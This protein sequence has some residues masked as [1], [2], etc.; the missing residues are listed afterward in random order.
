MGIPKI[1]CTCIDKCCAASSLL[2]SIALEEAAI[3]NILNAEGKKINKVLCLEECEVKTILDTNKS[4]QDTIEKIT[5]LENV[6]KDKLELIIPIIE[7]CC[8]KHHKMDVK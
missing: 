6:L 4:V 8:E 5:A 7:D 3:A 1:E 2:Q